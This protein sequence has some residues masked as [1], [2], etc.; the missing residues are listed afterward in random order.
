MHSLSAIAFLAPVDQV[1]EIGRR[2]AIAA[3]PDDPG[4]DWEF[5]VIQSDQINAFCL[6]GGKGA[7]YTGIIPVAKNIDGLAAI[8]VHEIFHAIARHGA[9]RMAHQKLAQLGTM[10][11]GMALGDMDPQTQHA[12]MWALGVGAHYGVLLPFSRDHESEADYMGLGYAARACYDLTEAPELWVRMALSHWSPST[13]GVHVDS[14]EPRH[15]HP[16]VWR[17]DARGFRN[18]QPKLQLGPGRAFP[19]RCGPV[20][21]SGLILCVVVDPVVH[22]TAVVPHQHVAGVPAVSVDVFCSSRLSV[23]V[24]EQ[25]PALLDGHAGEARREVGVYVQCKPAAIGMP[26]HNGVLGRRRNVLDRVQA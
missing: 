19:T 16:T 15:S 20:H 11:A 24:V 1:R 21:Q 5:N 13:V 22:R 7:V 25:R 17:V 18:P 23:E 4:F 8:M 9:G 6:P 14:S 3:G 2:I 26:A 12:V 10:A